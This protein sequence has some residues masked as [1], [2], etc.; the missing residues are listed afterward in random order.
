MTQN[1][2][3]NW[4]LPLTRRDGGALLLDEIDRTEIEV[5]VDGGA[6][7]TTLVIVQPDDAQTVMV[8]DA[9]VG[10]WHFRFFI[11]DTLGQAGVPHTEVVEVRDT[12][13]PGAVINV[14]VTLD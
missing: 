4:D 9:E 8:P 2:T 1:I 14:Q 3:I 13:P 12:S 10:E 7:F 6:N 11:F 5:S